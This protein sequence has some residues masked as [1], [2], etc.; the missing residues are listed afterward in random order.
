[1]KHTTL[2][3]LLYSNRQVIRFLTFFII[4]SVLVSGC[5][6]KAQ[7]NTVSP[8]ATDTITL[9]VNTPKVEPTATPS[10][11]VTPSITGRQPLSVCSGCSHTVC[12]FMNDIPIVISSDNEDLLLMEGKLQS[13]L[14]GAFNELGA[15]EENEG[16]FYINNTHG[17]SVTLSDRQAAF[18]ELGLHYCE[19]CNGAFDI[20]DGPLTELWQVDRE[21]F[22]IPT[23]EQ[24]AEALLRCDY[25]SI[26]LSGNTLFYTNEDTVLGTDSY[27]AG[28]CL[29][30]IIPA[31]REGGIDHAHIM[32]CNTEYALEPGGCGQAIS[33]LIPNGESEDIL[34]TVTVANYAISSLHVKESCL[35]TD[36]MLCHPIPDIRSGYPSSL[37]FSSVYVLSPSAA[38]AE[39]IAKACYS[40]SIEEGNTMLSEIDDT[41]AIYV[42]DDGSTY[43]TDGLTDLFGISFV[44]Q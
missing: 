11:T 1:M 3:N 7:P 32:F 43:C 40:R 5:G 19:L 37:G 17:S 21:D 34:A 41:Y 38:V 13:L 2:H 16:I 28:Y 29:D 22:T 35:I 14:S 12:F 39:I 20:T 27:L 9:P 30:S 31:L 24:V 42:M 33:L 25:R 15:T 6:R 26:L 4:L 36:E 10:V 8:A 23:E 44:T 18:L